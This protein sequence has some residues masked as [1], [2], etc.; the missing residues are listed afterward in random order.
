MEY[1]LSPNHVNYICN[2]TTLVEEHVVGVPGDDFMQNELSP[3]QERA[4][5]E[6][7]DE[8]TLAIYDLLKKPTL[9]ASDEKEVKKVAKETL[10]IYAPIANRLGINT[11]RVE[12]EDLCFFAMHPMRARRIQAALSSIHKKRDVLIEET[13]QIIASHLDSVNITADV[14]GREKHLFSIYQKFA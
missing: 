13:R 5:R 4:M 9:T 2:K 10:E 3:E 1:L 14:E 8:E 12:F 11:L 7:L 6:G